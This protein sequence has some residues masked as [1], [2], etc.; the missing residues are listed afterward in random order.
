[1]SDKT[2][3]VGTG[4]AAY[5]V[6]DLNQPEEAD[7]FL[8]G[9]NDGSKPESAPLAVDASKVVPRAVAADGEFLARTHGG[10]DA[11]WAIVRLSCGAEEGKSCGCGCNHGHVATVLSNETAVAWLIGKKFPPEHFPADLKDAYDAM[12]V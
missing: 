1:M 7:V 2:K 11:R 4:D 3:W 10:P 9:R 8:A 5:E 6:R 12:V